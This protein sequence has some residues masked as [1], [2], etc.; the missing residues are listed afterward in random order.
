MSDTREALKIWEAIL[1]MVDKEIADRTASCVR[2]KKMIVTEEPDG[3][4]IGV[5]EPFGNTIHIPYISTLSDAQVG[6]TVWVQWYFNNASTMHA[7]SFGDGGIGDL[8]PGVS[9]LHPV[10]SIYMTVSEW[11]PGDLFGGEWVRINGN[12]RYKPMD[13]TDGE[14]SESAA[15]S[16][17]VGRSRTAYPVGSVYMTV[18]DADPGDIFGGEWVRVNGNGAYAP[19]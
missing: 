1:P 10:G 17:A 15:E 12:E 9:A 8:G 19:E 2:G 5:R 3:D 14:E 11:N 7:V 13:E 6:D 18:T 16:H 4:V